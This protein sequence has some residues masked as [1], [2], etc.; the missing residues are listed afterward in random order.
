MKIVCFC[1]LVV[2]V[3]SCSIT[4]ASADLSDLGLTLTN[5]KNWIFQ[6]EKGDSETLADQKAPLIS[7]P[8]DEYKALDQR[9]T[10]E[11]T[12][13]N[14]RVLYAEM[15]RYGCTAVRVDVTDDT[16][17][18]RRS[19]YLVRDEGVVRSYT[20]SVDVTYQLTYDEAVQMLDMVQD[21]TITFD[22]K[23]EI[24]HILSGKPRIYEYFKLSMAGG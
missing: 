20:G 8:V 3:A 15:D 19:Y 18:V 23:V 13:D 10:D 24:A 5:L 4:P 7:H 1:L 12:D 6:D 11:A 2:V 16:E 9:V 14:L 21:E 17:S 22:E